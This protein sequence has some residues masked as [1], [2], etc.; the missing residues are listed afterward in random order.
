MTDLQEMQ[1]NRDVS[2]NWKLKISK[3]YY[4]LSTTVLDQSILIPIHIFRSLSQNRASLSLYIYY[5]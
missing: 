5:M 1:R 4:L 3:N 2:P